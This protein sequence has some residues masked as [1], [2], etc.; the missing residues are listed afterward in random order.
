MRREA[1]G[2]DEQENTNDHRPQP[3]D[4]HVPETEKGRELEKWG[5]EKGRGLKREG[6]REGREGEGTGDGEGGR[7]RGGGRRCSKLEGLNSR[8]HQADF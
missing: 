1:D 8:W 7:G 3:S 6:K 5:E 2:A 4:T